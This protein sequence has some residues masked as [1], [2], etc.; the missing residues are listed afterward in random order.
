ML[1][2][3]FVKHNLPIRTSDHLGSLQAFSDNPTVSKITCERTKVTAYLNEAI[4]P[5]CK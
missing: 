4:A 2:N 3:F 5:E 1:T